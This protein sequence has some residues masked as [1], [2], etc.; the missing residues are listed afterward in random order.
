MHK[1]KKLKIK[2]NRRG[3]VGEV[4]EDFPAFV[5]I[6][7]MLLILVVFTVL[8]Y[9]GETKARQQKIDE[10]T[11]QDQM[12]IMLNSLMQEKQDSGKNFADLVRSKDPRAMTRLNQEI[13]RIYAVYNQRGGIK[14]NVG[15]SVNIYYADVFNECLKTDK[16][17][18][19]TCFYIPGNELILIKVI[20][21][22]GSI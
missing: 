2:R 8:M 7:L 19:N 5:V 20:T 17:G 6:A 1:M 12:E 15:G 16:F 3:Q 18:K 4:I 22:Y 14:V 13:E 21:F 9:K 11:I 10:K